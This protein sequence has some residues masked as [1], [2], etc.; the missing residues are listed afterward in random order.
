MD[1]IHSKTEITQGLVRNSYGGGS[2][3]EELDVVV[4]EK[5][6]EKHTKLEVE[7]SERAYTE[8]ELK[9]MFQRCITRIEKEILG[10]NKS[11]DRI[12]TDMNLLTELSDMPV[13][14]SWE[15]DRYDVMN[16]YG[17][18]QETELN[19]E[20]TLVQ[21]RGT[22]TYLENPQKQALYEC[23]IM[24]FPKTLSK[25]EQKRS[26]IQSLIKEE[27][28][29]TQTEE[30]LNLP[31]RVNGEK[32]SYY[33]QMDSR[34]GVILVMAI[35]IGILFVALEKQ[36]QEQE[37]TKIK[38]Q[39]IS[40]YPEIISK[41]TLFIGAGMTVKR[42]WKKIAADYEAQKPDWGIRYAYEEMK[43]TCNEMDSGVTEAESYERFGKRCNLQEYVKLGAM[44]SQNL[45]KGT[46]DLNQILRMEAMQTF[47]ERKA[48]AKRLG[49]EAG[50]KMLVPMFLMLAE[51]LIVVVVPAFM[52]VQM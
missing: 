44:L 38:L 47:E 49:E 5:E 2:R 51:V 26:A 24:V 35:L 27:D 3:Q 15:L 43:R 41:L 19:P 48:R 46:K 10:S 17:E 23:K 13:E 22:I 20:G 50:T 1:L 28:E 34:G 16:V 32:L 42:A 11:A 25:E 37:A 18:I 30:R 31:D 12:E 29:R 9:S 52:S 8:K 7:V 33:S 6:G 36:N 14:I 40:D 39:M 21:L 4:Q 45:R